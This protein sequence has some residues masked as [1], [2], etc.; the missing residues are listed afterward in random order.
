[1]NRARS[2]AAVLLALPACGGGLDADPPVKETGCPPSH[3]LVEGRC[4]MREI[5]VPGGTFVMGR[6]YCPTAGIFEEPANYECALAD[7]PRTVTVEPFYVDATVRTLLEEI[8]TPALVLPENC[9]A[10][11]LDCAPPETYAPVLADTLSAVPDGMYP[12]VLETIC[13]NAGKRH[14]TEAEWEF[15]AT[16]GGTRTYPWGDEPPTCDDGNID[17]QACDVRNQIE[18]DNAYSGGRYLAVSRVASYPPSPEGVYD[19]AG[20]PGELV[21]A[22]P[23]AYGADYT[24]IPTS[25]QS[26]VDEPQCPQDTWVTVTASRGGRVGGPA[27][28]F[29]AAHRGTSRD[30]ALTES[31][32]R[33]MAWRCARTAE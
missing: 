8:P 3:E 28:H 17:P 20:N 10:A 31:G 6:G 22:S 14:L 26:C 13:H 19:L 25:Y 4:R 16:G 9:D 29:R 30:R 18:W 11:T 7:A 24:P 15:I 23:E 12:S 5:Y 27:T 1:M 21:A 32:P 33:G 2:L